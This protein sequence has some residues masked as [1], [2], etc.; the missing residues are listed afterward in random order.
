MKKIFATIILAFSFFLGAHTAFAGFGITPPYLRSNTLTQGSH[1]TQEIIIVRGDPVEDLKAE[2]TLSVPGINQWIT[3]DKG[4]NFILP[5][6]QQQVPITLSVDVPKDAEFGAYTG[7][8]RIRTSSFQEATTGVSIALGAQVDV[9]LK[10]VDEI[11]DFDVRRVELSEAE[12]GHKVWWL[13]FPGKIKFWMHIEN[14]GNVP[15]APERV[16]FDIYSKVGAKLLESVDST[17]DI[18]KIEPFATKKV[19]AELPTWLPPGG[20]LLKFSVYKKDQVSKSGELTLSILPRG[21][22]PGYEGYGFMGLSLG[23]KLSVIGPIG[24]PI[25]LGGGYRIIRPRR[26]RAPGRRKKTDMEQEEETSVPVRHHEAVA[27]APVTR[28]SVPI[29]HGAV[30]DLKKRNKE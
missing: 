19:L 11:Y 17:N 18:E 21:T 12:E 24:A 10:V 26:R 9:D 3:V 6:G 20:Y 28:R 1:F 13:D 22:I 15:V 7:N 8:I 5:K 29:S 2:I 16:H 23:D 14:T 30:V 25:F 4:L 27:K